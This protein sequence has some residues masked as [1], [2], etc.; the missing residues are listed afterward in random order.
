MYA[1]VKTGGKQYRVSKGDVITI[2]KLDVEQG[3]SVELSEVLLI[4]D[5]AGTTVGSPFIEGAAVIGSVVENGKSKKVITFKYKAKKDYRKKQGHRQ[6]F[7]MIEVKDIVAA[8]M[9]AETKK[10]APKAEAKTEEIAAPVADVSIKS[11]KK[12]ELI[13]FAKKNNIAID[14]KATNAILI[15]TIEEAIK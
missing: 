15:A 3:Q 6:P 9:K 1:I 13:D 12:A 2:E 11:M 10:S 7:T 4:S 5:E 8:G 14:E